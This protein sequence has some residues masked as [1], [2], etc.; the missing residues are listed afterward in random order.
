MEKK[1]EVF[2]C[3]ARE[4][5]LLRRELEKQLI[6]LGREGLIDVWYDGEIIAG[7]EWRPAIEYHLNSA[8]VILLLVSPDFLASDYCYSVEMTR[9]LERHRR[10]EAL[11]IPII[12]RPV[13]WQ[14]SPLGELQ[15][16]P[17][18]A[19]PITSSYWHNLDEAFFDVAR[20]IRRGIKKLSSSSPLP[21]SSSVAPSLPVTSRSIRSRRSVL[22]GI[23]AVVI[24]SVV[25]GV[26]ALLN[27]LHNGPIQIQVATLL[28]NNSDGKPP[29]N[30]ARIAVS[31]E[32]NTI[33]GYNLVFTP[34]YDDDPNVSAQNII[35]QLVGNALVAGVVGP[36]YSNGAEKEIPIANQAS[37]AMI[38]PSNTNPCFTQSSEAADCGG[39][40]NLIP[41]LR[42][43]G[44]VTY[45][46][47]ATTDDHQGSVMADYLYKTQHYKSAYVINDAQSYGIDI[48]NTFSTEWKKLDGKLEGYSTWSEITSSLLAHITFLK[49]DVIYFGGSAA[50]G[51]LLRQQ[52][53]PFPTLQ[54]TPFAGGDQ[55][56]NQP[57]AQAIVS[58]VFATADASSDPQNLTT[59]FVKYGYGAAGYDCMKIL[60]AAI[61]NAIK[62]GAK[63]PSSSTD[64]A[65]AKK[66]RQ[67]VIDALKE[68]KY[69]GL[70]GYHTFDANGDTTHKS[71]LIKRLDNKSNGYNWPVLV[72]VPVP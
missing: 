55:I 9:A 15:A 41:T 12:L 21:S 17:K 13:H 46:R 5:E 67:A 68:T 31:E 63:V 69:P 24:T 26:I 59:K 53:Q 70:T 45:F 36:F 58:P 2:L 43:T 62:G 56:I 14:G 29:E 16:L 44:N 39:A 27:F 54:N 8:Q 61:K 30:G 47:I 32:A 20:G 10:G 42:P 23:V 64:A 60:V 25:G 6:I 18:D 57:F 52:M 72:S 1:P 50:M 7:T 28:P 11:V 49:P 4:D 38:S 51:K 65:T 35:E 40:N 71:I 66:F 37:L 34:K 48:A 22:A 19:Q 33:T 3:Y